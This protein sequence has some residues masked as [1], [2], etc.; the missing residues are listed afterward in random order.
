[1]CGSKARHRA[2]SSVAVNRYNIIDVEVLVEGI[3][4]ATAKMRNTSVRRNPRTTIKHPQPATKL[5][6]MTKLIL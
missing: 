4:E 3:K 6:R 2:F 5:V 1:L